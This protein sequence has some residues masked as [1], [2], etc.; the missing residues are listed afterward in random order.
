G[1]SPMRD[2]IEGDQQL[3]LNFLKP[4]G[5]RIVVS[6]ADGHV[7]ALMVDRPRASTP[8]RNCPDIKVAAGGLLELQVPFQCLDAQKDSTVAFI[9]ALN[10]SG[11]EV[12]HHPRHQPIELQVPD[13]RF[14][15]KNWTT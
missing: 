10:R 8:S 9:V 14:P 15:S 11:A 1:P 7:R 5:C 6:G 12:E 3:S 4:E 13:E 2:V